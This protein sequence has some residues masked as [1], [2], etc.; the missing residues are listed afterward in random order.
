MISALDPDPELDFQSFLAIPDSD[1]DPVKSRI[2]T[3]LRVIRSLG[4]YFCFTMNHKFRTGLNECPLRL[5]V[6]GELPVSVMEEVREKLECETFN[7]A[8]RLRSPSLLAVLPIFVVIL[9]SA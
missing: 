9:A 8:N 4:H 5:G 6:A 2:V 3:L 1:L 7:D